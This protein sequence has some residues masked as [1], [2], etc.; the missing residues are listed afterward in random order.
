MNK[1]MRLTAVG[2]GVRRSGQNTRIRWRRDVRRLSRLPP[3]PLIN[4]IK[5]IPRAC[6]GK[7]IQGILK[8]SFRSVQRKLAEKKSSN[9]PRHGAKAECSI[10]N[11]HKEA[12]HDDQFEFE[13]EC[14][15]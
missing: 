2:N 1:T 4:F 9:P 7:S 10:T 13:S 11:G 8:R 5:N 6:L 12:H 3:P 15:V 14:E